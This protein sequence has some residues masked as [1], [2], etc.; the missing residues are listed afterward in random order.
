MPCGLPTPRAHRAELE[1]VGDAPVTSLQ[2]GV[3]V[4]GLARGSDHLVG[5]RKA[6][7]DTIGPPQ[8]YMSRAEG[9]GECARV[10]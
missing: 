3:A 8:R 1:Q 6:L 9:G 7:L 2:F 10:A 4:A 5:Y